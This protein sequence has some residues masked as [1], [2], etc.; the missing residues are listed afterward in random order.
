MIDRNE[1]HEGMDVRGP[2]GEKLGRVVSSTDDSF[3]FE[4][5]FFFV[6]DHAVSYGDVAEIV[7]DTI[8]LSRLREE[9]AQ[10]ERAPSMRHERRVDWPCYGDEGGGGFL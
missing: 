4:K 8:Q 3:V 9:S 10:N 1:V 5:G 7:G 6:T 2:K